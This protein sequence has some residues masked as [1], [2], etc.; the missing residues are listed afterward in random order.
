MASCHERT[1][2]GFVRPGLNNRG[3]TLFEMIVVIT[4]IS[5]LAIFA[6]DYYRK[7]MV[8]V[9]QSTL[10]YNLGALRSAVAMKFAENF[11]SGN[12]KELL[13]L[14]DSNPMDLLAERPK[15]YLG[16]VRSAEERELEPGNWYFA[17]DG[18]ILVYLV[19]NRDYF[20]SPLEGAPRIRFK[21]Y[22]VFSEKMKGT[23]AINFV[24]G[25]ELR[26]MDPYRWSSPIVL[27][28]PKP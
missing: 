14:V 17:I 6:L 9:E 16:V 22:P 2:C 20:N 21:V 7:L 5:V 13:K 25:L 3:F 8:E 1:S 18:K 12:E 26:A 23:Q 11:V 28:K 10:E 15:N 19:R 27:N 24:S 4:I